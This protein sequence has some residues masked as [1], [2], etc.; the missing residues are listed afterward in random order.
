[1]KPS[2]FLTPQ[3]EQLLLKQLQTSVIKSH[4]KFVTGSDEVKALISNTVSA[5]RRSSRVSTI[6]EMNAEVIAQVTAVITAKLAQSPDWLDSAVDNGNGTFTI[7]KKPRVTADTI[8]SLPM[9]AAHSARA[10]D[11]RDRDPKTTTSKLVDT[12]F[13]LPDMATHRENDSRFAITGQT[14]QV[15]PLPVEMDSKM[16]PFHGYEP[17]PLPPVYVVPE[18]DLVP[19]FA[20]KT[21]PLNDVPAPDPR[22]TTSVPPLL[23]SVQETD[24]FVTKTVFIDVSSA[25]RDI[26]AMNNNSESKYNFTV[27]FDS[28]HSAAE[29]SVIYTPIFQNNPVDID[30]KKNVNYN[31]NSVLGSIVDYAKTT[32]V[33]RTPSTLRIHGATVENVTELFV[34]AVYI[35]CTKDEVASVKDKPFY[36]NSTQRFHSIM[37]YPYLWLEVENLHGTVYRSTNRTSDK[38]VIKLVHEKTYNDELF[39]E[40]GHFAFHPQCGESFSFLPL[41]PQLRQLHFRILNPSGEVL[42]HTGEHMDI[43]TISITSDTTLSIYNLTIQTHSFFEKSRLCADM[44]VVFSNLV[45]FQKTM[46]SSWS[47]TATSPFSNDWDSS[48]SSVAG[49]VLFLQDTPGHLITSVGSASN[50]AS[51]LVNTFTIRYPYKITFTDGSS[52]PV[53]F[54]NDTVTNLQSELQG[55]EVTRGSVY[56]STDQTRVSLR[57]LTKHRKSVVRSEASR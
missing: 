20:P 16:H 11:Q 3:N 54:G 30:H 18:D 32:Y 9:T 8:T 17:R 2:F 27:L 31:S 48:T 46:W 49:L 15:P 45:F 21:Q 10:Q 51:S 26:N 34:D 42:R 47:T 50:T 35:F 53:T 29:Q 13:E 39:D 6:S 25:D 40:G 43:K 56:A 1:M 44:E 7:V 19:F 38:A 41:L 5:Y 52:S 14:P 37:H 22:L 55:L 12:L 28:A 23:E 24:P 36:I 57:A 33:S 4:A